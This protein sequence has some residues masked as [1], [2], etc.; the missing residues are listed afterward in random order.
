MWDSNDLSRKLKKHRNIA[1]SFF[2]EAWIKA[3]YKNYESV[4]NPRRE[5]EIMN[6]TK[7]A[8]MVYRAALNFAIE[9]E[10]KNTNF[11][12]IEERTCSLVYIHPDTNEYFPDE[13]K[14]PYKIHDLLSSNLKFMERKKIVSILGGM[15]VGKSTFFRQL[16]KFCLEE[17]KTPIYLEFR[18]WNQIEN[19]NC[20]VCNFINLSYTTIKNQIEI[21]VERGEAE[22]AIYEKFATKKEKIT[23]ALTKQL[24]NTTSFLLFDAL[25]EFPE[26]FL[27]FLKAFDDLS[28][29]GHRIFISGRVHTIEKFEIGIQKQSR[30]SRNF[31]RNLEEITQNNKLRK[32]QKKENAHKTKNL[33][34]M[35]LNDLTDFQV[36]RYVETFYK[37][38]GKVD[39]DVTNVREL[40]PSKKRFPELSYK[41]P[42][43][44]RVLLKYFS[45]HKA[46][47]L[48]PYKIL[49][50]MAKDTFEWY[51]KSL[52][53]REEKDAYKIVDI[54][55]ERIKE[56]FKV[57]CELARNLVLE[58]F[59]GTRENVLK[60]VSQ[61]N[62]FKFV[63]IVKSF[64]VKDKNVGFI[65]S[66]VTSQS[67][68]D[69]KQK[70][71]FVPNRMQDFFVLHDIIKLLIKNNEK[72]LETS[73]AIMLKIAKNLHNYR[74]F[75]ELLVDSFEDEI[76]TE[77]S[78]LNFLRHVFEKMPKE[79]L[80][81][82]KCEKQH[83]QLITNFA[84]WAA[85]FSPDFSLKVYKLNFVINIISHFINDLQIL[86]DFNRNW[87]AS[88]EKFTIENGRV[89]TFDLSDMKLYFLPEKLFS[90]ES[91]RRLDL[92]FNKLPSL[93]VSISSLQELQELNLGY[94]QL[95]SLPKSFSSLKK[96]QELNLGYNQLSS[97]PKN[98]ASLKKLQALN[99]ESNQ[100]SSLPK[101]I[102]LLKKLQ[103]LSL[104]HNQM[105]SLP[106]SIVLL[107][108]LQGLD[109]RNNKL[110]LLP[111][112][113]SSLQELQDLNLGYNQ[114]SSLPKSFS[115]LKKLQELNLESNQLS[116]LP[117]NIALL[118]KLQNLS[119]GHNQ[120]SSL[121]KSIVLL[122][123]LQGLDLRNNKLSSL[124]E[125]ISSLQELQFLGLFYNWFSSLPESIFSLKK[126]Q[127]LWLSNNQ[128]SFLPESISS[129]KK[130]RIL[131]LGNNKLSSLP[132]SISSLQELQW[133]DLSDNQL[134]SLPESIFSLKKL[135]WLY[136]S[137]N[138]LSS[139]S[140]SFPLHQELQKL[141][142]AFNRLS[143]IP[144]SVSSLHNLQELKINDNL[145][146]S[147]P[148]SI[149]S[150]QKLHVL[151]LYNNLLFFVPGSIS[152]L[153]EL[154]ELYLFNN[155]LS[156]LPE[157][158]P[159]LENLRTLY[160]D[161]KLAS[162]PS[163]NMKMILKKL[164][165]NG[166][167][168]QQW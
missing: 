79:K 57:H 45:K 71:Q 96:L 114:L 90:F 30:Y 162:S 163:K 126:L 123:K 155:Q 1:L 122:K 121:P 141:D 72:Y 60:Q 164:R 92:S 93:P 84:N 74:N 148:E 143:S 134:S 109:S 95:S 80:V 2:G 89:L 142:L 146:S 36:D 151:K 138:K 18:Y 33:R 20:N 154:Q 15:G 119:L 161:A 127:E 129:L 11:K 91:L 128:L 12:L 53:E 157:S 160:L 25:D 3:F 116:S 115:S 88:N 75:V 168:I 106:K 26:D 156:S 68:E 59:Q 133:L 54:Q 63:D 52:P 111:E 153:Q 5:N 100:L 105:S 117:K 39:K 112:N 17:N 42:L 78:A 82:Y 7:N 97:L 55:E 101:N 10:L 99:L 35:Q 150:L 27:Q 145:L 46:E 14:E 8:L 130:L 135:R 108:K 158:I 77:N 139:L 44:L 87:Y 19:S 76:S 113:I 4:L 65:H 140:E 38:N 165:K 23:I 47:A 104:G 118:K 132:K 137:S 61:Q 49:F 69:V 31:D 81:F 66:L 124:P 22:P 28:D 40:A 51:L 13:A 94:N 83:S 41:N 37:Q 149:C 32:K 43:V 21:L 85:N 62:N 103:H 107:K 9:K 125:N 70:Y 131:N 73:L 48:T 167:E 56:L 29:K 120:M 86:L 6:E 64:V 98:I 147:L 50:G 159:S 110:S 24:Q 67:S 136:L 16:A 152:L 102:A 166:C 58:K 144:E 34:T